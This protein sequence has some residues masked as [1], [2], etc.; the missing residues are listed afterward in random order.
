MLRGLK[1]IA[2]AQDHAIQLVTNDDLVGYLQPRFLSFVFFADKQLVD[3]ALSI[4]AKRRVLRSFAK[5]ILYMGAR[6]ISSIRIK[7]LAILRFVVQTFPPELQPECFEAWNAFVRTL[8]M[9]S[10][11]EW[12]KNANIF[13]FRNI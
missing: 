5:M 7:L 11:S 2:H 4:K 12:N 3:P 13:P 1:W 10:L 8:D 6:N 9:A